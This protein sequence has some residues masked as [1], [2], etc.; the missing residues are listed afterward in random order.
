MASIYERALGEDIARLHP[1]I[2]ER[3]GFGSGDGVASVGEGVMHRV[4]TSKWTA[5]PL[6]IGTS[7]H[8]MFPE[9]G[10]EIPFTIENFA[11][12][13]SYG[14]ET[15]TWIR[16]FAFGSRVRHFDATMIYSSRRGRIVDYLGNKQHLAVD[17]DLAPTPGGGIRIRSGNQRFYEG[18]LQFPFPAA[19]T[20]I[21]DVCE[22]YDDREDAYKITVNVRN[23]VLGP[24]FGYEGTFRA[25]LVPCGT[26]DIPDRVKPLREELRE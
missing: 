19:I 14:R 21:A 6:L 18:S 1:R 4:W 7:R 26:A 9:S 11:Y 8:I 10:T 12:R 16:K 5:L 25:Q 22:W 24:V 3:F 20:G 23:P 2:R 17:L 13:D 15:V